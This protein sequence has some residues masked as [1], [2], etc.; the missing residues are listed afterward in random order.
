MLNFLNNNVNKLSTASNSAY[1]IIMMSE[2]EFHHLLALQQEQ[3][4]SFLLD[5]S[6][7][8]E[9]VK[10]ADEC[11]NKT[12]DYRNDVD[13]LSDNEQDGISKESSHKCDDSINSNDKKIACIKNN[14]KTN[15][16]SNI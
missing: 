1:N 14:R 5:S 2:E 16:F 15:R 10:N 9:Q 8:L 3:I 12:T 11:D 13:D 4:K 6:I 7:F